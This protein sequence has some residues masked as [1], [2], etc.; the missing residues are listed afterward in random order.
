MYEA[1]D[2]SNGPT[3]L[4]RLPQEI[5]GITPPF[6]GLAGYYIPPLKPNPEIFDIASYCT[7]ELQ[8][9]RSK[10]LEVCADRYG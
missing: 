2:Y 5:W 4:R 7:N 8:I 1:L 9:C 6:S 10:R 3:T